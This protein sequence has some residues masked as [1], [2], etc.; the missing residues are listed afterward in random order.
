MFSNRHS[1]QN[2][3]QPN[4]TKLTTLLFWHKQSRE[5]KKHFNWLCLKKTKFI[6]LN[7]KIDKLQQSFFYNISRLQLN[8]LWFVIHNK[9]LSFHNWILCYIY[10]ILSTLCYI[11]WTISRQLKKSIKITTNLHHCE[12]YLVP[13]NC[14]CL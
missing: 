2:E 7:F 12:V 14:N 10:W 3:W 9:V 1:R 8:G 5:T 13:S 4:G 11:Q 6:F